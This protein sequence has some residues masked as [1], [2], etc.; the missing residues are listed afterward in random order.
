MKEEELYI[1]LLVSGFF[2]IYFIPAIILAV[3]HQ[4][5][6]EYMIALTIFLFVGSILWPK[7][8]VLRG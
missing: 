8:M 3:F 1:I 4:G 2:A 7:D 5:P 6:I